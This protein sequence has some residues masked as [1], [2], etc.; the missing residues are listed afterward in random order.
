MLLKL[1]IGSSNTMLRTKALQINIESP[2]FDLKKLS[3]DMV[4]TM[5]KE[6]GV[7]LAA[8]QIGKSVRIIAVGSENDPIVMVNPE[9]TFTS[10]EKA[11]ANE[12][13]LSL[14]GEE[15][16]IER[17][18]KVRFKY[19]T[20]DGRKIKAKA[21]GLFARVVQHEI[22]HLNGILIPDKIYGK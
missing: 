7:G 14:P 10:K 11:V 6:K 17:A 4:E 16:K 2:G 12:G 9:I 3:Q 20:I 5:Q 22:D 15:Y 1:E 18:K 8:P 21:K 13:C 19:Y